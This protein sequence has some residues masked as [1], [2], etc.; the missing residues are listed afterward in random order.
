[1]FFAHSMPEKF[2]NTTVTGHFVFCLRKTQAGKSIDNRDVIALEKLR[3][4]IFFS[5]Q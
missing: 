2:E 1:M 3:F 4:N 5:S